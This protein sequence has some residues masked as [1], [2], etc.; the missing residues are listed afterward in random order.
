VSNSS[1]CNDTNNA[2]NPAA[3]EICNT[4]DDDCD[5]QINEGVGNTYYADADGDGYGNASS[6]TVACTQP[7]GY[8]TNSTDCNDGNASINPAATEVCNTAD[9]DCDGQINEGVGNTY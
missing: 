5:G 1:D 8:V 9:D 4:A 2:I 6:S 7:S 3:T